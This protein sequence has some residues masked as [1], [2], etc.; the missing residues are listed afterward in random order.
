LIE[1]NRLPPSGRVGGNGISIFNRAIHAIDRP[2]MKRRALLVRVVMTALLSL[3]AQP[4]HS[5][6]Y[7]S[8]SIRQ[9]VPY[10]PGGIVDYIGRLLGQKLSEGFGQSV[11]VDNRPGAGGVIGIETASRANGDGYTLVL[12]D[13][14]IVINPSLLPKVPYDIHK[15]LVPVTILSNSPLVLTINAKV[16]ATSVSELVDLA[17]SQ[18][19]KLSFASAGVGTTPHM[20]GELLKARIQQSIVHVPYKGAGPA[21]TDLLGGQVQMAFSSIT[22]ALPFIKDG[23]LRGLATTG[24]KRVAALPNVPTMIE[25]GFAGFEVNLWLGLFTPSS[26][27]KNTVATLNSEIRKA[28]AN[29]AVAGGF[30]K[31][32]A[33]PLGNTPPE[34]AAYVKSEFNK[35]NK[36]I[37]DGKLRGE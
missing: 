36:V 14:A 24:S 7:P 1:L 31:V 29:P 17:K 34:A 33:E 9:I 16:P 25:A 35:W 37:R 3:A 8:K 4:A 23:R 26:T 19:G 6:A 10:A 18:P 30:E 13:P 5:Q 15:D 11:V 2:I 22:A 27:P 32:G 20:A 12:M 28:L 21:M